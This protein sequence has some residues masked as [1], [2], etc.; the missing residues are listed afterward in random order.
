MKRYK[1]WFIKR[2]S[3]DNLFK[4]ITHIGGLTED[5]YRWIIS[6][7]DAISGIETGRWSFYVQH[8]GSQ[9]NLIIAQTPDGQKYL[10]SETEYDRPNTLLN[11]P[12]FS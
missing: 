6:L 7:D 10:K 12:T 3:S 9:E 2:R 8:N 5:F 4:Q 11:L 1:V